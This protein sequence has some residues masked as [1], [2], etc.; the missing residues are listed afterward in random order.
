MFSQD[1]DALRRV[2]FDAWRK[3]KAGMP[4]QPLEQ[5]VVE[6]ARRHPEYHH[7]LDTGD[8]ALNRDW[9][10]EHGE[11][12][13]F[14]H[15]G[16]HIAVLEQVTTDRLPG[17]RKLYQQMIGRCLGDQHEAEHRIMECLA[18]A[19]WKAQRDGGDPNAKALL[20]C[21]KKRGGGHRPGH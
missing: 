4:L 13:P 21:I 5:Q 8:D 14:L 1:R 20:K 19:M 17:I 6:V 11:S 15:M 9:L 18:E 10:P 3:A 12:N 16:L 7:L 2:Y